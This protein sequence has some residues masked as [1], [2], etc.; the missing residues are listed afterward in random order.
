MFTMT[1]TPEA[2]DLCHD[3]L[4]YFIMKRIA[5]LLSTFHYAHFYYVTRLHQDA[6]HLDTA[7]LFVSG[8]S[9]T[10]TVRK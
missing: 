8:S 7:P 1:T 5:A 4:N 9:N 3:N 10:S 2:E 6:E